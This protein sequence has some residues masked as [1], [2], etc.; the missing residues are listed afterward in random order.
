[1]TRVSEQEAR[2]IIAK[3]IDTVCLEQYLFKEAHDGKIS[4]IDKA[5]VKVFEYDAASS[6]TVTSFI[7]YFSDALEEN[8]L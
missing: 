4:L 7:K 8:L 3:L 1:M 2:E 6:Y 5:G